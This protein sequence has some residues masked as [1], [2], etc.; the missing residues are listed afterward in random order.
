MWRPADMACAGPSWR[1]ISAPRDARAPSI[2]IA[3]EPVHCGLR[4]GL[5]PA[6]ATCMSCLCGALSRRAASCQRAQSAGVYLFSPV[7]IESSSHM[8][9]HARL[10]RHV[11][12]RGGRPCASEELPRSWRR[13]STAL[14]TAHRW[15]TMYSCT[16]A[17]RSRLPLRHWHCLSPQCL[18]R[19]RDPTILVPGISATV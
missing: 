13:S 14:I 12:S 4:T 18:D 11:P 16:V 15:N 17:Q 2:P 19:S 1:R 9:M 6:A 7:E 3:E 8:V 10:G 5:R